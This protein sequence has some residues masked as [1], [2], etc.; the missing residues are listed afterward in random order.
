MLRELGRKFKENLEQARAEIKGE[1]RSQARMILNGRDVPGV[2]EKMTESRN[3]RGPGTAPQAV[4]GMFIRTKDG[5]PMAY[6]DDGSLRHATG[7]KP[8]K[9]AR[10]ARKKEMRRRHRGGK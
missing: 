4:P 6:F 2:A 1:A 8:G 9:A 5:N 10:K 7:F 3:E